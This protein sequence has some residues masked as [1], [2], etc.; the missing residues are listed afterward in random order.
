MSTWVA[1]ICGISAGVPDLQVPSLRFS[2]IQLSL[3][4]GIERAGQPRTVSPS[5]ETSPLHGDIA[6]LVRKASKS[7]A[8]GRAFSLH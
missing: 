3:S 5:A 6:E 1:T 2:L 8:W 4:R 7:S